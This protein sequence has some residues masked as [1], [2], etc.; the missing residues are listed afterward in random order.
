MGVVEKDGEQFVFRQDDGEVTARFGSIEE[1]RVLSHKGNRF[2]RWVFNL[3]VLAGVF[4][5]TLIFI[6][7]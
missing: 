7:N 2:Y 3:L 6:L 4:Y 1:K 5:L